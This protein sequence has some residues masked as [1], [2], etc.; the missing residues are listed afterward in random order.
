MN[1]QPAEHRLDAK[2]AA[3]HQGANQAGDVGADHPERRT[4]QH[5][6]RDAVLGAGEGIEGQRNQDD[7]VGQ[8]NRQQRLANAQAKVGGEYPAQGV[9]RHAD[10][11]PDP[12]GGDVPFVPGAFVHLGRRDVVVVPG[13]VEDVAGGVQFVQPVAL[14]DLRCVLLH[15]RS[16]VVLIIVLIGDPLQDRGPDDGRRTDNF[17]R[18]AKVSAAPINNHAGHVADALGASIK[19]M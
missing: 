10:R 2:P 12:Q 1:G 14:D 5:R 17:Y 7:D 18:P 4:Q 13:A 3:G 16:T 11:H 8:Q 6:K 19:S 15:G 9:G